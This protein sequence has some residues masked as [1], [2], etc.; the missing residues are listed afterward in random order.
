MWQRSK[1]WQSIGRNAL[2]QPA[3]LCPGR[4][5]CACGAVPMGFTGVGI[6]A[7]SF[8]AKMIGGGC[9]PQ[10]G[11]TLQS[12]VDSQYHSTSSWASLDQL[13]WL[14]LDVLKRHPLPLPEPDP[15][16][17]GTS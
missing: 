12:K 3:L 9:C 14:C 11:A 15:Q 10:P 7:I 4:G 2:R 6:A 8:T 13:L 16:L 1:T 5:G 17:Q